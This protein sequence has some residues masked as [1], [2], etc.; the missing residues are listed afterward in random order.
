MNIIIKTSS[1]PLSSVTTAI[2]SITYDSHDVRLLFLI[3]SPASETACV[4]FIRR[5]QLFAIKRLILRMSKRFELDAV[6][7]DH[8]KYSRLCTNSLHWGLIFH[9]DWIELQGLIISETRCT[10]DNHPLLF[11]QVFFLHY[12]HLT[13]ESLEATDFSISCLDCSTC[14]ILSDGQPMSSTT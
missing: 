9:C 10:P 8:R 14:N 12:F 11:Y 2:K 5:W 6:I 7:A 1:L 13:T 4:I 3:N